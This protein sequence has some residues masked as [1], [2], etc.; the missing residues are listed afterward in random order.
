MYLPFRPYHFYLD[1][2]GLWGPISC[3]SGWELSHN[4]YPSTPFYLN[5]SL[6]KIGIQDASFYL[7]SCLD[8][9]FILDKP[10]YLESCLDKIVILDKAFYL[11]YVI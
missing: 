6:D 9:W 1:K 2:N 11:N 3:L 8:K 10:F 5:K 7:G 4:G